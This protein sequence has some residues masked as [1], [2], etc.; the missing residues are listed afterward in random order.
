MMQ[1]QFLNPID[2]FVV[3]QLVVGILIAVFL[4]YFSKYV[5]TRLS[6]NFSGKMK[7]NLLTLIPII[8]IIIIVIL[9][10]FMFTLLVKPTTA[11]LV[12]LLGASG[13]AIGFA[14]KDY[15][16]SI[17]AGIVSLYE[18]QY[19]PGD[20]IEINGIYGEV[21][22]S[23]M[24]SIK[25]LTPD[26]TV[27]NIPQQLLWNTP[28]FNSNTGERELLCIANFY[29]EPNHNSQ[30][31]RQLLYDVGLTSPLLKL[32]KPINVIISEKPY[33]THY[34]LKAYPIEA[35]DQFRFITDLTSRG[36]QSLI[37]HGFQLV[38]YQIKELK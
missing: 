37:E 4:I 19:K 3:F 36:K 22:S 35:K 30:L 34:R 29:L 5:I 18:L 28:L 27:V 21:L 38:E 2:E 32:K 12:A 8:R 17:I 15:V 24:R 23:D 31:A 7:Y 33:F 9:L 13:V 20:W 6:G 14:F 1:D 11:N 25:I 16:S 10:I 26:D